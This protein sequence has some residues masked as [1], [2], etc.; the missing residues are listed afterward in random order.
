MRQKVAALD[1]CKDSDD[2][3]L[4]PLLDLL[5]GCCMAGF[6]IPQPTPIHPGERSRVSVSC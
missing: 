4:A 2:G 6:E 3:Q 1:D 5:A